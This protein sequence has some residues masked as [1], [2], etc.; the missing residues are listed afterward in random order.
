MGTLEGGEI[1]TWERGASQRTPTLLNQTLDIIMHCIHN[2]H[3]VQ[4]RHAVLEIC[5]CMYFYCTVVLNL[6]FG[7]SSVGESSLDGLTTTVGPSASSH[8]AVAQ[9]EESEYTE[10]DEQSEEDGGSDGDDEGTLMTGAS[11]SPSS[12]GE[13]LRGGSVGGASM[14]T[15]GGSR[16]GTPKDGFAR[17][18]APLSKQ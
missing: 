14:D 2:I 9:L 6:N 8:P 13:G 17:P 11:S 10:E 1:G 3:S 18:K 15:F 5:T 7:S 16:K 4:C 12:R